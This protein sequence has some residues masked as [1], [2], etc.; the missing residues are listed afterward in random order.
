LIDL[1]PEGGY[2]GGM[3]ISQGTP[4]EVVADA[5]RSGSFTGKFLQPVLERSV[6]FAQ[7]Q[8]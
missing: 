4:E 2:R 3:I 1:G 7:P 5:E 8:S 6:A